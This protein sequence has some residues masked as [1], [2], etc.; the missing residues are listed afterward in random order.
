[1]KVAIVELLPQLPHLGFFHVF[2]FYGPL[3]LA[4]KLQEAGHEVAVFIEE[5]STFTVEDM[6]AFDIVCFS[7][8]SPTANR[9]YRM[10]D[11]LRSKGK[12]TIM[13]GV[14]AS[15]FVSDC[16]AH[17][18]YV[19]SGEGDDSLP[20]LV[21]CIQD[22]KDPSRVPG[23]SYRTCGQTV[24]SNRSVPTKHLDV[25]ADYSLI[26][27]IDKWTR[28][29]RLIRGKRV[30]MPVQTSRGCPKKCSFCMVA[31]MFGPLYRKR[32]ISSVITELR[33]ARSYS[34]SVF[35][36]DNNFV[37]SSDT[38]VS[39]TMALLE[40]IRDSE[41]DIEA[42]VFTTID[43]ADRP[44]LLRAMFLAGIRTVIIGFESLD[45][46]ALCRYGKPRSENTMA[47]AIDHIR[48]QG[49]RVA[50]SFIASAD[51]DPPATIT[52]T[53]RE[54]VRSNIDLMYYFFETHYPQ[55]IRNPSLRSR[56]FLD[57]WDHLTGHH[58]CIFPVKAPPSH[59]QE[60]LHEAVQTGG[61]K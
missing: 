56:V 20:V 26:R 3:I 16:L 30:M 59:F 32:P 13:G 17:C 33:A 46:D 24:S 25:V 5:V 39:R 42:S 1:M 52:D 18:D 31:D 35:F 8:K 49:I 60:A 6:E 15:Y 2:P 12:T 19:I 41:L 40:A 44:Q 21:Q 27:G 45:S 50:G 61:S 9:T 48:Q 14:H 54:A 7:V 55:K 22:K 51:Y 43:I 37:G 53:A 34:R 23:L 57:D 58:V 47:T 4:S 36:V 10:S 38:E 29:R 11:E 28:W